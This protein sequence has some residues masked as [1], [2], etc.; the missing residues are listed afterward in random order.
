MIHNRKH[1]CVSAHT[2]T[3]GIWQEMLQNSE[4]KWRLGGG[5][6][7]RKKGKRDLAREGT[8]VCGKTT[9]GKRKLAL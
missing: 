9:L 5:T 4:M 1:K 3:K 6:E 8:R 2:Q 7:E